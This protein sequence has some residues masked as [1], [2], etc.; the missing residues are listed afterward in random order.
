MVVAHPDDEIIFGGNDLINDKDWLI[1]FC[2]NDFKR[3]EMV[4]KISKNMN[5]DYIIL[6]HV[7]TQI[8]NIRFHPKILQLI[9]SI[10]KNNDIKKIVTHNSAGE[11]GHPQHILVHKMI[12]HLVYNLN[13]HN[14]YTFY[15]NNKK[16]L[17]TEIID[18]KSTNLKIYNR[19]PERWPQI[20]YYISQKTEPNNYEL[21]DIILCE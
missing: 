5:Y 8:K 21:K 7:D 12:S 1:V 2:T 19:L 16:R 13:T 15:D 18:I 14:L 4:E 3:L 10:I 6:N 17:S 20:N 9:C 11:Y